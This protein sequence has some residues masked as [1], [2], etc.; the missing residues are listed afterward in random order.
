[1]CREGKLEKLSRRMVPIAPV[2]TLIMTASA[3]ADMI[4]ASYVEDTREPVMVPSLM[5]SADIVGSHD[6]PYEPIAVDL[7][8]PDS[9]CSPA[10]DAMSEQPASAG[11]TYQILDEEHGSLDLCL[12]ALLGHSLTIESRCLCH[13]AARFVQT[14][15]T[16]VPSGGTGVRL[17]AF[18]LCPS[19]YGAHLLAERGPPIAPPYAVRLCSLYEAT[20]GLVDMTNS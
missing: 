5:P 11:R 2:M 12:Y 10:P 9:L 20:G 6:T 16:G 4:L 17:R 7:G 18:R 1:M 19:L 15:S 14:K 3:R 13:M 8:W